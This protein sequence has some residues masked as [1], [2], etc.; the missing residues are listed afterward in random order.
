M[1]NS[2]LYFKKYQKSKNAISHIN[3]QLSII[4]EELAYFN[5]LKSQIKV[6]DLKDALE[7]QQELIDNHYMIL[8]SKPEKLQK[9]KITTYL[10]PS[11]HTVLV[12]K[13]IFKMIL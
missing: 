8:K 11:G 7:I 2:K 1:G 9:T 10:L 6:C 4:E 3:E 5:I 12:G 13:I